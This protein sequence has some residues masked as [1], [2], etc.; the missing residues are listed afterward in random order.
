V[1]DVGTGFGALVF[2]LQS[3]RTDL[4]ITGV[5][6]ESGLVEEAQVAGRSLGLDR[7]RFEIGD[8]T[9]LAS[10]DATFDLVMCQ[11]LLAHVPD[12]RVVVAEMA[13]VLKPGGTL[14]AAEWTDRALYALPVDNVLS[15]DLE[16]APEVYRLTKAY[17]KGR[18]VLGRGDDEAGLRAALYAFEAGLE[19]VDVRFSDRVWHA[20]PPYRKP[21]EQEWRE[22]ARGWT[23]AAV[24]AGY[25]TWVNENIRAA[26]GTADD[27]RRFIEL[28]ENPDNKNAWRQA[29]ETG[30]FAVVSTIVMVLTIA[31]KPA[32][33]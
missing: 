30:R 2:L 22:S 15:R 33:S 19:V 32:S 6:S 11:T 4:D 17:S 8:A 23:S 27:A 18:R 10:R 14:F 24:D 29:I 7:V 20:I 13:R 21:S 26:G 12:P 9:R 16:D 25:V 28:T 1:L 31:R 3:V 5:D